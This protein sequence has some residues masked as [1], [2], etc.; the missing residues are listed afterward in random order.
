MNRSA[1][2]LIFAVVGLLLKTCAQV[3]AAQARFV[4][5]PHGTT[6][7]Q[8]KLETSGKLTLLTPPDV[9]VPGHHEVEQIVVAPGGRFAYSPM[10]DSHGIAQFAIDSLGHLHALEKP[11][12]NADSHPNTIVLSPN[13]RCAYASCS[14]GAIVEYKLT[15]SGNLRGIGAAAVDRD[16]SALK[17]DSTGHFAYVVADGDLDSDGRIMNRHVFMFVIDPNGKLRPFDKRRIDKND[18]DFGIGFAAKPSAQSV[19]KS[20]SSP[21]RSERF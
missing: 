18:P 16:P 13:G 4:Y 10:W 1:W 5:V 7:W 11:Y 9:L 6:I 14:H 12:V 8:Y 2:T 19:G 20:E 15:A 3:D 21:E 17:I